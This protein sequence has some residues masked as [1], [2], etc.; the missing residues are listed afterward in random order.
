MNKVKYIIVY[1]FPIPPF[2]VLIHSRA[3]FIHL[4]SVFA[5]LKA[6]ETT[7][8][9]S[10]PIGAHP[11]TAPFLLCNKREQWQRNDR[12]LL[13]KPQSLG[14]LWSRSA[15]VNPCCVMM[16]CLLNHRRPQ[17]TSAISTRVGNNVKSTGERRKRTHLWK[18]GVAIATTGG[19]PLREGCNC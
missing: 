4:H 17:Q 9:C 19:W 13:K 12:G 3:P 10:A 14:M 8:S 1:L 6:V 5:A 18:P 16:P 7:S 11:K 15:V 2:L